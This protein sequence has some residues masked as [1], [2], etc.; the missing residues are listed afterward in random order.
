[1]SSKTNGFTQ[2]TVLKVAYTMLGLTGCVV[3]A[4]AGISFLR[5]KRLTVSDCLVYFAFACHATM[6]AL[7][8][9]LSPY[10]QR[11]YHVANGRI[12]PYP[13]MGE[14]E[15]K[16]SKQIFAAHFLF[17]MTLWSIKFSLLF[18]YRTL[19]IGLTRNY[20]I[21]WWSIA[22]ICIVVSRLKLVIQML[23]V[24]AR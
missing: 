2:G 20:T 15:V 21:I 24:A 14:N 5:P 23:K 12:P 11:L 6:C 7:Y 9:S 16:N 18:L 13:E 17:W 8:M 22:G 19:L 10:P 1:M 3:L 4:K